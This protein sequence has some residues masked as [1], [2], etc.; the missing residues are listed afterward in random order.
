MCAVAR[1]KINLACYV[2]IRRLRALQSF[3]NSVAFGFLDCLEHFAPSKTNIR[4]HHGRFSESSR[5]YYA[6]GSLRVP[7]DIE[8]LVSVVLL[9]NSQ[10]KVETEN[11]LPLRHVLSVT[12]FV[13]YVAQLR[14]MLLCSLN[15]NLVFAIHTFVVEQR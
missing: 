9:L 11:C 15:I 12:E 1:L 13:L 4:V 6:L 3:L 5:R 7:L 10:L 2:L 14:C 8:V